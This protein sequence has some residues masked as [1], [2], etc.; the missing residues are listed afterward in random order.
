MHVTNDLEYTG[1][2]ITGLDSPFS[3]I[4]FLY[5][6]AGWVMPFH[7]H[8]YY[9]FLLVISGDLLIMTEGSE[10]RLE[11][12]MVSLIPPNYK[13]LLRTNNGYRQFGINLINMP[14]ETELLKILQS[15]ITT[16]CVLDV[17]E[18]LGLIP[19]IEDCSRLHTIVSLHKIRNRL[20]YML[21]A[22]IDLLQKRDSEQVFKEKITVFFRNQICGLITLED[23]S[24]HLSM[25]QTH[26]ER[27]SYR[28]FGCGAIKLFN[29]LK[30]DRARFLLISTNMSISEISDHLGYCDQAYFSKI[31]KKY[32]G[33]S[34]HAYKNERRQ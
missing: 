23:I 31:F 19:E 5:R 28:E 21:L 16:P 32:V 13:H 25:S 33:V 12:G 34:P 9:Q 14:A 10:S 27:L 2:I 18:L 22:Y 6:S 30:I 15:N 1:Q 17:P 11:R 8:R 4:N 26:I 3:D 29:R 7:Q 24:R 20:E